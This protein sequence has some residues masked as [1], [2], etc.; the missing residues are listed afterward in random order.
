M[1][2]CRLKNFPRM[3][4][5]FV[6]R[7]LVISTVVIRR[8]RVSSKITLLAGRIAYRCR[9]GRPFRDYRKV[10][11]KHPE[12]VSGLIQPKQQRGARLAGLSWR[13][14]ARLRKPSPMFSKTRSALRAALRALLFRPANPGAR[15]R[16]MHWH[17]SAIAFR[18][19]R[20]RSSATK[21][22]LRI[23]YFEVR[24]RTKK[25]A[26]SYFRLKAKR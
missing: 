26:V 17:R 24:F 11:G 14:G 9:S 4:E 8:K 16:S 18:R 22:Q 25:Y 20:A 7:P 19:L 23:G 5:W 13:S 21:E 3:S 15:H 12:F 2:D 6:D 1:D 10:L